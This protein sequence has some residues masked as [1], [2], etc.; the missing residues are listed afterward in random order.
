MLPFKVVNQGGKPYLTVEMKS[1]KMKLM[2]PKE[3]ISM[4]LKGIKQKAESHLGKEIEKAMLTHPAFSFSSAQFQTIEDA[5][6]TVGLKVR[7]LYDAA[8]AAYV[9]YGRMTK[10]KEANIL[11]FDLGGSTLDVTVLITQGRFDE[12]FFYHGLARNGSTHLGGEDFDHRVMA[13]FLNLIKNKY[14]RDISGD[15]QALARLKEECEKAKKV[16]SDQPHVHIKIE[17]LF[18]EVDFSETLSR[19]KFEEL[20]MDLF[21]KTIKLVEQCL[22]DSGLEKK[23]IDDIVL[24]GGSTRIP[25][26]RELLNDFFDGREPNEVSNPDEAI[27][28]GAGTEG[29][30]TSGQLYRNSMFGLLLKPVVGANIGIETAGG[31][32]V[33]F[34]PW[35]T[36]YMELPLEETQVVTTN[37]DNQNTVAIRV[38]TGK[39]KL[40]NIGNFD[41]TGI[42]PAPRGVPQ[43]EVKF[44][45]DRH[46]KVKVSALEKATNKSNAITIGHVHN[47]ELRE[48][49]ELDALER[50][51]I[52]TGGKKIDRDNNNTCSELRE[53]MAKKFALL[54]ANGTGLRNEEEVIAFLPVLTERSERTEMVQNV[55]RV[56]DNETCAVR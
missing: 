37:K 54:D 17:S 48:V 5:G 27:A 8:A 15:K 25:K 29:A 1:G 23:D 4:M 26:V 22:K 20:N 50:E 40:R 16:L 45:M 46:G 47:H 12:D 36:L 3:I 51:C 19:E 24:V 14:N 6:A 53:T 35:C 7:V 44:Y 38:Y 33:R 21:Q 30:L 18:D 10:R 9:N 55:N 52:I 11:V 32:M 13:Y 56:Y 49:A 41:L 42:P 43:I 31:V 2:S 34:I 28:R 39:S